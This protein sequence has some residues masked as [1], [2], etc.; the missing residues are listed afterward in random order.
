MY[1]GFLPFPNNDDR[2]RNEFGRVEGLLP[3]PATRRNEFPVCDR[4]YNQSFWKRCTAD[5]VNSNGFLRLCFLQLDPCELQ[6]FPNGVYLTVFNNGQNA[7]LHTWYVINQFFFICWFF[8]L[9]CL[10]L[11][12]FVVSFY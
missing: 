8:F 5:R 12:W 2:N 11:V 10:V 7:P 3:Q 6:R 1:I 9:F 4:N